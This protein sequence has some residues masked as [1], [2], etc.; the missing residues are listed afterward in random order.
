MLSLI[1]GLIF[2][3]GAFYN[4]FI[5]GDIVESIGGFVISFILFTVYF[6]NVREKKRSQEFLNWITNNEVDIYDRRALYKGIKI[7][8]DTEIV[9]F[10]LCMSFLIMTFKIPSRYYVKGH[11]NTYLVSGMYSLISLIFGWW[12]IPWGPIY[13]VQVVAQNIKGGKIFTVKSLLSYDNS[14]KTFNY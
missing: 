12:G 11:Y 9:Q 7:E 4:L 3:I 8:P 10:Q 6:V 2:C 1:I 5:T 14:N 13:T